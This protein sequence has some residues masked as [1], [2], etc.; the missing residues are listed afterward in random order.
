ME[1]KITNIYAIVCRAVATGGWVCVQHPLLI[2]HE[3]FQVD[4]QKI[5]R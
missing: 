2:A 5:F 3:P 4:F 1:S